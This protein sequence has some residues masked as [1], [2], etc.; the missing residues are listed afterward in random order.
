ML[1]H[2]YVHLHEDVAAADELALHKH[3]RTTTIGP[4]R[5][6]GAFSTLLPHMSMCIS[7]KM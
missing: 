6:R 1:P 5:W 2:V 3:L 4:K 7:I